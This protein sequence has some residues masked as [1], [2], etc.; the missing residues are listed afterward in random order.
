MKTECEGQE[1]ARSVPESTNGIEHNAV[2]KN[3]GNVKS[4]R[5]AVNAMCFHCMGCTA[6]NYEPGTKIAIRECTSTTCPLW[7]FRPYKE[8]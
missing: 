3:L 7:H 4:L 1:A 8:Q 5:L 2:V 6:E